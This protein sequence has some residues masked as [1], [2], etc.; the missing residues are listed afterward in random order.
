MNTIHAELSVKI[1]IHAPHKI[2]SNNSSSTPAT[3][4]LYSSP[5]HLAHIYIR[6]HPYRQ[7][8]IAMVTGFNV[9]R[10]CHDQ[11]GCCVVITLLACCTAAALRAYCKVPFVCVCGGGGVVFGGVINHQKICCQRK[12]SRSPHILVIVTVTHTIAL[13]LTPVFTITLTSA[14]IALGV[15]WKVTPKVDDMT[16][17]WANRRICGQ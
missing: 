8:C 16:R 15:T 6:T 12:C 4:S 17:D 2:Y 13:I 9:T 14:T 7:C 1:G 10:T 11:G 3:T 5:D